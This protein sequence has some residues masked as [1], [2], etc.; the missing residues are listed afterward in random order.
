MLV[1]CGCD[2]LFAIEDNGIS[3]AFKPAIVSGST[4]S[5]WSALETSLPADVYAGAPYLRKMPSGETVLSIQSAEGRYN[6]G[7]LDYSRMV[8]YIGDQSAH[9]FTNGSEPFAVAPQATGLWN[10]L[11]VKNSVT[12]TA[13]STTTI[14]GVSGI[15]TIDGAL[16]YPNDNFP[17]GIRSMA[18]R[19]RASDTDPECRTHTKGQ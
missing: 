17:G 8:V 12:V 1:E 14:N 5:R 3:G 11:F 4:G 2:S 19:R 9:G 13:I 18:A 7:T 6:S 10:S 16:A 15:W